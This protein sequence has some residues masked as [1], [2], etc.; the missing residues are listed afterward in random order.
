VETGRNADRSTETDARQVS[1][2]NGKPAPDL[3]TQNALLPP[4]NLRE[5]TQNPT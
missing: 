5:N 3:L 2:Q 1:P 4:Q